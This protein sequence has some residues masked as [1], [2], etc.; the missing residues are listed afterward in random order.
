MCARCTGG[1]GW[2]T[3]RTAPVPDEEAYND[4][5]VMQLEAEDALSDG[6]LAEAKELA[7]RCIA[8]FGQLGPHWLGS[9]RRVRSLLIKALCAS[10]PEEAGAVL[11][12]A[13]RA[14]QREL[15]PTHP[16]ALDC[17]EMYAAL[18]SQQGRHEQV[19]RRAH[20]SEAWFFCRVQRGETCDPHATRSNV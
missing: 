11:L 13:K 20:G 18:L 1:L 12:E 4:H 7:A 3:A 14:A 9:P 6:D 2:G 16:M 10:E 19:S 17:Y 8:Y 5:A 15:G